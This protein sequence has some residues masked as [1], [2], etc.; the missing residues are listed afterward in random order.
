MR[1]MSTRSK[2][3]GLL[4][5]IAVVALFV[6]SLPAL[7]QTPGTTPT[8]TAT[9]RPTATPAA[10]AA[11]VGP[12]VKIVTPL[13]NG[14][15]FAGPIA[16]ALQ[17]SGFT[18]VDKLGQANIPGQ[19]HIHYF[20]D[21]TPPTAPGQPAVTAAGTYVATIDIFNVWNNVG[22][23]QHTFS[24]ELV[25]NDHTPLVPPVAA[26][27]RVTV[28]P[29]PTA[30]PAVTPRPTV[31]PT[32]TVTP[33]ATVTPTPTVRPTVTPTPTPTV[34][35]TVT[36]T[37][38]V[39]PTVTPTPTATP[40]AT[41]TP[42]PTVRPTVTPTPTPTARPTVTPAA[43]AAAGPQIKIVAPLNNS[44]DFPGPIVVA[45]QVSGFTLA[46][47]LGQ[48]NVPGQGHIHY[49]LDVTP[50][51]A[52][53]QPAVTAAGTYVASIDIFNIWN[54]VGPG[55]HT[56][57]VELVNNNHTP[58][59]PPVVDQ[60]IVTVLPPVMVTPAVTPRPTVTPT[61]TVRPTVT[62]TPTPTVRP[63][64]TATPLATPRPTVTPAATPRPTPAANIVTI[65]DK[66]FVPKTITIK[67]GQVVSWVNADSVRHT[68]K[69]DGWASRD[70]LPGQSFCVL[71]P[72]AGTF[73][74]KDPSSADPGMMGTVI[75]Q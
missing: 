1:K 7:A 24:A 58:L 8:P 18:L 16:V 73:N 51:T 4:A 69:G 67:A 66:Q 41:V 47:K 50:P 26:Q 9:V 27:A 75:V 28:V 31:T 49:F 62:P 56:F 44:F 17:V 13:D 6:S 33:L 20:L 55:Q 11:A 5:I 14:F 43:T 64:P 2:V 65:R 29:L 10:T 23:G 30:T 74:Y 39:R 45:V 25:N 34:R 60:V 61:P 52:P 57:S 68:V 21:V 15:S 46:D 40:L 3:L 38:T 22:P 59:V 32:P 48:A 53:G 19:G 42:A 12:Q 36:P 72:G 71:F 37:P 35:P 63:T 54:N 70:I